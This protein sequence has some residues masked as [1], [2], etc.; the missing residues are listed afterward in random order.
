MTNH[1]AKTTNNTVIM[2]TQQKVDDRSPY[3]KE[4]H[5]RRAD[6]GHISRD[7][8]IIELRYKSAKNMGQAD[9]DELQEVNRRLNE[10]VENI[11]MKFADMS[12]RYPDK[13]NDIE[14]AQEEIHS[15]YLAAR[16]IYDEVCTI[17]RKKFEK[18]LATGPP[19]HAQAKEPGKVDT[20]IEP[21]KLT[22]KFTPQQFERWA[23]QYT[24]F[25]HAN[26]MNK[27]N[28]MEQM[29]YLQRCLDTELTTFVHGILPDGADIL[30]GA[31]PFLRER[32]SKQYPLAA[33]RNKFF[34]AKYTP[35]MNPLVYYYQLKELMNQA[36]LDRLPNWEILNSKFIASIPIDKLKDEL[37]KIPHP[38]EADV[39]RTIDELALTSN[40]ER[41]CSVDQPDGLTTD[42]GPLE[43]ASAAMK[44]DQKP[45]A[46]P[47][48]PSSGACNSCGNKG[49]FRSECK[50]LKATCNKCGKTGHIAKVCRSSKP[51]SAKEAQEAFQD[52]AEAVRA[53]AEVVNLTRMSGGYKEGVSPTPRKK[54]YFATVSGETK[55]YFT[56]N[57]LPD[58]G[59]SRTVFNTSILKRQGVPWDARTNLYCK[60]ADDKL[61]QCQG[62]I[63]LRVKAEPD[64]QP[65]LIKAL[66]CNKLTQEILMS[67]KDLIALGILH[68]NFPNVC[69]SQR[70]E[71]AAVAA[72]TTAVPVGEETDLHFNTA[73]QLKEHVLK[74]FHDIIKDTLDNGP[75]NCEPMK[76]EFKTGPKPT[77]FRAT[78]ARTIPL[79][80]EKKAKEMIKMLIEKGVIEEVS[81]VSEWV[82]SAFFVD[83]PNSDKIR[84]VTD[85][86]KINKHLQR[87]IHPFPST[88]EVLEGIRSDS[89][90]FAALDA[91]EGYHQMEIR[92]EDRHL[93]TFLLPFGRFRY[94][95][96]P[97]GL[98]PTSDNWCRKSDEAIVGSEYTKKI[99]DDICVQAP[100]LDCMW[101]RL[102]P[103]LQNSRKLNLTLSKKKFNIGSSIKFAGH[104]ISD[105]G[106]EPKSDA[107]T[108]ITDFPV[109][110]TVS[111]LLSFLGM[112]QQLASFMPDYAHNTVIMSGLL[113]KKNSF[114]WT[115]DHQE[116]FTRVKKLLTSDPLVKPFDISLK[117]ELYTDASKLNGLG[118]A[119]IQR[120]ADG[121]PRL[122]QCGSCLLSPAEKN[123]AVVELEALG[124]AYAMNKA[125]YYLDGIEHFELFVDHRP[126]V[127][128][129]AKQLADIDNNRLLRIRLKTTAFNFT[130][131]WRPGKNHCIADAL[132]RFPV[133]QPQTDIIDSQEVMR[134]HAKAI[135]LLEPCK[136]ILDEAIVDQ[137]YQ[138]VIHCLDND[139]TPEEL[140]DSHPAQKFRASWHDLST[141]G[142]DEKL[143]IIHGS[144]IVI[145]EKCR[146]FI[147]KELHRS[148]SGLEKTLISARQLYFWPQMSSDI[149]EHVAKCVACSETQPA[150]QK[151]FIAET[152]DP[153]APMSD[154]GLD[155]FHCD[156]KDYLIMMCRYS[157]WP[158][159]SEMKR[160]TAED[161][162]RVL[163]NWFQSWG[164]PLFIR[165]DGGPQ[166]ANQSFASFCRSNSITHQLSSAYNPQ[167]NGLAEAGVKNM[168]LLIQ[169]VN[170]GNENAG[171]ALL[172]FRNTCRKDGSS[173]AQLMFGRR[174]R[175]SL[176]S[177]TDH[178][179]VAT[180]AERQLSYADKVKVQIQ[181][182]DQFNK[183]ATEK[184]S[185]KPGQKVIVQHPLTKKWT[186]TCIV[187]S[188]EHNNEAFKVKNSANSKVFIRNVRYIRPDRTAG[189]ASPLPPITENK[190]NASIPSSSTIRRS[191]RLQEGKV[192]STYNRQ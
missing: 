5:S 43:A 96:G 170:R 137:G 59:C 139:K 155:M 19:A 62:Y 25:Y 111:K 78:T 140:P 13:A 21:E 69:Y 10:K 57:T 70:T 116:E 148:H 160:T 186:Q 20:K 178:L 65:I 6:K 122:I 147:M 75:M 106:I 82:S 123:Y 9:M 83:K 85:F 14:I 16:T 18:I 153:V 120:E 115:E 182:R 125:R 100:S 135:S 143:I 41:Y 165:S 49:H 134:E 114:V 97:M 27:R 175:G 183:R 130:V 80:K 44:F 187:L 131:T 71:T 145:P 60:L 28:P 129:F 4:L 56:H 174:L 54:M 31:I 104:I 89:K 142:G 36:D 33:R 7:V 189:P 35:G 144:K 138:E 109:P 1:Q 107:M 191:T 167:S 190:M 149:K 102:L 133:F 152:A 192:A 84:L 67:W 48:K 105:N 74:T 108:A 79:H 146:P 172:A 73:E 110:K 91:V 113:K 101:Q 29:Y 117:T 154:V 50:F 38:T 15:S 188:P 51:E 52:E 90:F 173:P 81:E 159:V 77:P 32:F 181:N 68:P 17:F 156:G 23:K 66:V 22:L 171:E 163:S 176:P 58:S 55:K 162:I 132:S 92:E 37:I 94:K 76:I 40:M 8:S 180:P 151:S 45:K 24:I 127:G 126:L 53:G 30:Q 46:R 95:R 63:D 184:D 3:Q 112:A 118:F 124:A 169:R 157:G 72:E 150:K 11:Q 39:T 141:I 128:L 103:V 136:N 98:A 47:Q 158:W 87:P 42:P 34:N 93:T 179:K 161:V 26:Q 177:L 88:K 168:K 164:K 119:L 121:R 166:F 12:I 99:V 185:F 61:I 64:Q 2:A 86:T